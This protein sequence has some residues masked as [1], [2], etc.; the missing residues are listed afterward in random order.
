MFHATSTSVGAPPMYD[1]VK[2]NV[3]F[4]VKQTAS[5]CLSNTPKLRYHL[6]KI[7]RGHGKCFGLDWIVCCHKCARAY[8]ICRALPSGLQR[9]RAPTRAERPGRSRRRAGTATRVTPC[10]AMA[11]AARTTFLRV[12]RQP[13]AQRERVRFNP[14]ELLPSGLERGAGS[15]ASPACQK[16]SS[17]PEHHLRAP[18]ST[19]MCVRVR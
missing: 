16:E 17:G 9:P 4:G 14:R 10:N 8:T 1:D 12:A 2:G 5:T 11:K 3:P 19:C 6:S 15:R 7:R 13:Q 18:L